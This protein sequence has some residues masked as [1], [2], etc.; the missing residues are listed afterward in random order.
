MK[1][2]IPRRLNHHLGQFHLK[3][4]AS[5]KVIQ[6]QASGNVCLKIRNRWKMFAGGIRNPGLWNTEFSLRESGITLTI[7]IYKES[8]IHC[9]ELGHHTVSLCSKRFRL[10]SKK[11][12]TEERYFRY[13]CAIFRVVF[14]SGSSFC[15]PKLHGNACYAGF[16]TAESRIQDCLGLQCTFYM[17]E[18]WHTMTRV[19][20]IRKTF[21]R[22]PRKNSTWSS[23]IKRERFFFRLGDKAEL[24]GCRH[25]FVDAILSAAFKG[26]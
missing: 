5:C 11:R 24:V 1:R 20:F 3:L 17:G 8:I 9:W 23:F 7:G 10:V 18:T 6:T 21:T 14:D 22:N 15:A 12:K 13:T 4:F 16:H 2:S 25:A 19:L 26:T